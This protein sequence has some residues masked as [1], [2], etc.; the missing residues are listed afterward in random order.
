[1][2]KN[3]ENNNSMMMRIKDFFNRP[4]PLIIVLIAIICF[5]LLFISKNSVGSRI[6]V[7]EINKDD[8]QVGSVHYFVNGDMNYFYASNGIYNGE[9]KDTKVYTYQLGYYVV[10]SNN[11]Y[12]E[13]LTRSKEADTAASLAD[14]VNELSG[15]SLAESMSN[16]K[17]FTNDIMKNLNNLHLVIKASTKKGS[18]EAD[19]SLDYRVELNKITKK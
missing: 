4:A 1:M 6:Y 5:L 18:K 3:M 2:T 17:F 9:H 14:I 16:R 13:F 15:W 10:D 7:G 12:H 19:I 8:I 11:E